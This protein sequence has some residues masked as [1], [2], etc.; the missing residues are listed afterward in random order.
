MVA[1]WSQFHASGARQVVWRHFA[2]GLETTKHQKANLVLR[3]LS[4]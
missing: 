3:P 4:L 1:M 2:D